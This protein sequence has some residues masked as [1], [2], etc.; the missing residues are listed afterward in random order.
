ME[1]MEIDSAPK[2]GT[3]FQAWIKSEYREDDFGFWEPRCRFNE[4][5]ALGIWRRVDYDGEGWDYGLIHL[6]ATHWMPLPQPPT[7][8]E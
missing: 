2:D 6:R 4:D 5:G 8:K 7:E 1:W 3:E